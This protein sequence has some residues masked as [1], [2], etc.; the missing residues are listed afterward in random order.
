MSR[1]ELWGLV[2]LV[3]GSLV[4]AAWL[5]SSPART[6][7][8]SAPQ[9]LPA[10]P[11]SS[12]MAVRSTVAA[13]S[14]TQR[15]ELARAWSDLAWVIERDQTLRTT[16]QLRM[17]LTQFEALLFARTSLA[18]AFPGFS[19]AANQLL[20]TRLG[21][22]DKP[23]DRSAAVAALHELANACDPSFQEDAR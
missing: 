14:S 12:F 10:Q 17:T 5:V 4:F 2:L 13:A 11:D 19:A 22:E 21:A 8:R 18:G 3:C 16:A 6:Y 23:I 15:R 1:T 7:E 9:T 20:L